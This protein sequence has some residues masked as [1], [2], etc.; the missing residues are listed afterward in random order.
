MT[1]TPTLPTA[2]QVAEARDKAYRLKDRALGQEPSDEADNAYRAYR[3]LVRQFPSGRVPAPPVW[4]AIPP[5]NQLS[6]NNTNKKE[7]TR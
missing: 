4:W 5:Y 2:A 7:H 6:N 3:D 1:D